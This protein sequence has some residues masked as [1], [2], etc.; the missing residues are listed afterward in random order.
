MDLN[1]LDKISRVM[2]RGVLNKGV[3]NRD[4]DATRLSYKHSDSI[5]VFQVNGLEETLL[6]T[7]ILTSRRDI[8]S[9]LGA[10]SLHEAYQ[11]FTKSLSRP[12][13][14]EVVDFNEY[15]VEVDVDLFKIPFVKFYREDGGYYLTSSIYIAC[16]E[17]ICNA[18]FHRTMYLDRDRAVLRIV[19]RHLHYIVSKYVEKGV[20]APVALVLG[21]DPYH[22][23][24]AATSPPLGVFELTIG[25]ELGG[26]QKIAKTPVYG[27][28]VPA[29]ASIVVE[30]VI[31]RSVRARE[32]PF[33]DILRLVDVEREEPV[34]IAQH[35]YLS[36]KRPLLVHSIAPGLQEHQLL[37]GFPREA[38]MYS[39]VKR[40]V[41]CVEETRLTSGGS[42]W[43]HAVISVNRKCSEGDAK[44]A[45]IAA[46][47]A[48]PSI[49]HIL[50][51]D[52]DIDI[53]NPLELEWAISTRVKAS[54]DI[55]II[56]DIRGSTLD[57]RSIDGL[58]DKVVVLALKPRSEPEDKYRLVEVP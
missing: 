8:T 12:G 3:V 5:V 6:Y 48:H 24:A 50:I 10:K 58:G 41:P 31:S 21:L 51:V 32:G 9:L 55:I 46:I 53:E 33:V 22:E 26:E 19:P 30:G 1:D 2:G 57:P 18:S 34:F 25:A 16:Y 45:A 42:T 40:V 4:Y 20:D 13:R 29:N 14:L 27:I 43:L 54:R 39:E 17:S 44:L 52:N 35:L 56:P 7:N 37:M 47:T 28:P 49:K 36:R 15:F 38:L 11:V 23:I